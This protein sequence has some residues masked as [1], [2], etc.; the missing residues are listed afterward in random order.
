VDV[1]LAAAARHGFPITREELEEVVATNDKQRFALDGDRIRANQ[2]HTVDV[3]L[4][5]TPADPPDVLFHGTPQQNEKS[6]LEGGLWKGARHHVHLSADVETATRVGAR[7]GKP[8]LFE[9]DAR[10]MAR[11]GIRFFR[12]ANGVWLVDEVPPRY[13]R[14]VTS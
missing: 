10:A 11:D 8:I 1:V 12:S 5:L 7:R 13:L 4:E 6:I 3:D 2:G 9:I 14:R